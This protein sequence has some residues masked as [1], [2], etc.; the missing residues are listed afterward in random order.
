[1][2]ALIKAAP[3]DLE[4]ARQRDSRMEG[5][6]RASYFLVHEYWFIFPP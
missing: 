1:M 6:A 4:T 3:F 2:Q 5:A